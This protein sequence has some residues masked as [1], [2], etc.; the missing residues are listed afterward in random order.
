MEMRLQAACLR[1]C[2]QRIRGHCPTP[3]ACRRAPAPN[4][5]PPAYGDSTAAPLRLRAGSNLS[6]GRPLPW[7]TA[8]P[9][10][11][12]RRWRR[13]R[14]GGGEGGCGLQ[15][16]SA[17]ARLRGG[18]LP[19]GVAVAPPS[20][21]H[22]SAHRTGLPPGGA[23]SRC[24]RL[25]AECGGRAAACC[26]VA[27]AAGCRGGGRGGRRRRWGWRKGGRRGGQ[28]AQNLQEAAEA[29]AGE[30]GLRRP[31]CRWSP[32]AGGGAR[33]GIR[34]ERAAGAACARHA[35]AERCGP[36]PP[37]AR[38]VC[39]PPR[40]ER[41]PAPPCL[42][43]L[44]S[45]PLISRPLA[46]QVSGGGRHLWVAQLYALEPLAEGGASRPTAG[47]APT[48]RRDG[49]ESVEGARLTRPRACSGPARGEQ[50]A[51]PLAGGAAARRA[52]GCSA[53]E[54]SPP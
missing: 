8:A 16:G 12:P 3:A 31:G 21:R 41:R 48:S 53:R 35:C 42:A 13:R 32:G 23:A 52:C 34:L 33:L 29:G 1:R 39:T 22:R 49:R 6:R 50:R 24:R 51:R 38:L 30:A 11:V 9:V 26:D 27:G 2:R 37:T 43:P 14:G 28:G 15:L 40:S 36:G 17:A 46:P 4:P 5:P 18:G 44:T 54:A 47:A 20:Q 7:R 10:T 45:R 19:G 25:A